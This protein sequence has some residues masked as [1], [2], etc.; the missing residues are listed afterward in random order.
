M[1]PV[2]TVA[3]VD[4]ER[5]TRIRPN[6]YLPQSFPGMVWHQQLLVV[7]VAVGAGVVVGGVDAGA[8]AFRMITNNTSR[9]LVMMVNLL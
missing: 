4:L 5:A 7:D 8:D 2:P 1:P 6:V 9:M 3:R